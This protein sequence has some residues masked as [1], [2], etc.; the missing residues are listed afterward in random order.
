VENSFWERTY[1]Y[2]KTDYEIVVLIS[3]FI[4]YLTDNTGHVHY[5]N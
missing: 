1:N 3:R 2:R 5:E 4:S